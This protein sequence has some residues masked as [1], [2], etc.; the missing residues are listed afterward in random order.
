MKRLSLMLV[1]FTMCLMSSGLALRA[2][3]QQSDEQAIRSVYDSFAAA[4]KLKDTAKLMSLYV[5]DETLLV[6]DVVPPRQYA[7]AKAY[8]KDWEDFFAAFPGPVQFDISDLAI[9]SDHGLAYAHSIQHLVLADKDG[10]KSDLT[11]RVT[12]IFRKINGNWLIVHEHIS[13]PVDL[14]S[15]KPD[16][17]SKP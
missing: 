13:V 17:S 4:F 15:Q 6:F 7:G 14:M 8:K 10:K 16:L 1:A 2:S 5:P 3:A 12:D 9:T 11:V